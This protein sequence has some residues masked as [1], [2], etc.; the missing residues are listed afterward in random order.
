MAE[1]M[2]QT[3][4]ILVLL[5]LGFGV[6][7]ANT[8]LSLNNEPCVVRSTLIDLNPDTPHYYLTWLV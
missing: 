3:V 7:L 6:S 2:K 4:I 1:F 5:L 8:C